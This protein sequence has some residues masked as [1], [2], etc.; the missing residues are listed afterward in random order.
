MPTTLLLLPLR[1][2]FNMCWMKNRIHK[3]TSKLK[4]PSHRNHLHQNGTWKAVKLLLPH[5]LHLERN[6]LSEKE[7]ENV[8]NEAIIA[9]AP[10][11]TCEVILGHEQLQDRIRDTISN[12]IDCLFQFLEFN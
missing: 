4:N 6:I 12:A 8:L 10:V 5:L 9:N 1:M 11:L 2:W 7:K 3:E